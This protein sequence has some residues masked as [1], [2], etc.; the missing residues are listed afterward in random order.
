MKW[1]EEGYTVA[2][3]TEAGLANPDVAVSQ[4]LKE[5]EAAR[6]TEPKNVVGIIGKS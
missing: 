4:A 6:S 5:L 2:E 1:A 3:I